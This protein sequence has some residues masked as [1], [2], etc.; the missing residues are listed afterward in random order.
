MRGVIDTNI[1]ISAFLSAQG[2]P[3]QILRLALEG[4]LE[5]VF[6][7]HTVKEHWQVLH[8][9]KIRSRLRKLKISLKTAEGT[10]QR[11]VD[12]SHLVAGKVK[13]D[14]IAADP[15]DSIFLACAVEGH[16]D[17]AISGDHHLRDLETCQGIPIME[18]STLLEKFPK[19]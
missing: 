6:S 15:S 10:L 1:L 3:A 17:C 16:A 8:Y 7:P 13:V 2:A 14:I 9:S 19:A 5:L 4:K 18:P 12:I 11:L